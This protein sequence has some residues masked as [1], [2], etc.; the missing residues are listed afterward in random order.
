GKLGDSR[1]GTRMRGEGPVAEG[2]RRLFHLFRQRHL[3]GREMPP[4]NLTAFRRPPEGQLSL[5]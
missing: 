2:V 5:F 3:A 1:F 4:Y